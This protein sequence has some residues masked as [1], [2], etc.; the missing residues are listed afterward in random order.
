MKKIAVVLIMFL[1]ILNGAKSENKFSLLNYFSG[2]YI[3]YTSSP[4]GKDCIDLGFCFVNSKPVDD[5]VVGESITIENCEVASV[6]SVLNARVIKTEYL[7]DGTTVIYAYSNLIN[8]NVDVFG[9]NVNLQIATKDERT[10]IGW[11]LILGSF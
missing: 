10:V 1:I 11:P 4:S 6:I 5:C 9:K 2:E 8:E 3:A 7:E